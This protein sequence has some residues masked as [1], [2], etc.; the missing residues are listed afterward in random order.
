MLFIQFSVGIL[1]TV[2][3]VLIVLVVGLVGLLG[4][5]L[6]TTLI[7]V[8]INALIDGLQVQPVD[9]LVH[10]NQGIHRS[11][12]NGLLGWCVYG[13]ICVLIGLGI[14]LM[15]DLMAGL[16][17]G[18]AVGF[19]FGFRYGW[20]AVIQHYLLRL[21]LWRQGSM[22]LNYVRWLNTVCNLLLLQRAGNQYEFRHALL[23]DYLAHQTCSDGVALSTPPHTAE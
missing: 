11:L 12:T 6:F 4:S 8:L 13:L 15:S 19:G 21:C 9:S 2:E 7:Y 23:R 18:L 17:G 16:T 22:P 3:W 10:P 1:W 5:I 14:G 20:W